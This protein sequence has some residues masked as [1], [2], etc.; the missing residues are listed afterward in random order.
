MNE[1]FLFSKAFSSDFQKP[2]SLHYL[3]SWFHAKF[4][5]RF[6]FHL[7]LSLPA[8]RDNGM[9]IISIRVRYEN[10][11]KSF[12]LSCCREFASI[13]SLTIRFGRGSPMNTGLCESHLWVE[14]SVLLPSTTCQ[15]E[16]SRIRSLAAS[17]LHHTQDGLLPRT[18]S[19]KVQVGKYLD[20][21]IL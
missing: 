16:P 6:S 18:A 14:T 8:I 4:F 15:I 9:A 3:I 12:S 10:R 13:N 20:L 19:M 7:N 2:L 21:Y 5:S 1:N 11:S 17:K